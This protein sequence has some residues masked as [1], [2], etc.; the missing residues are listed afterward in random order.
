MSGQLE[1]LL[2][3]AGRAPSAH[4]T[5]PW[6]VSPSG[7]LGYALSWDAARELPVGDPTRR[8]LFLALGAFTEAFL[9]ASADLGVPLRVEWTG[10]SERGPV[11]R[12]VRAYE[13]HPT[14]FTAADLA[15]RRSARGAYEPGALPDAVF[16][17]A[18]DAFAGSA[19]L[20][21]GGTRAL[22]P[23]SEEADRWLF[24][25][26]AL[27]AELRRWLRLRPV[28]AGHPDARDGLTGPALALSRVEERA[29]RAAL[30]PAAHRVLR[31]VGL[32]RALAAALRG[33]MRYDGTVLVVTAPTV[34][35]EPKHLLEAGR[36]LLRCWLTLARHGY[37][38]H[39]LSQLIDCGRTCGELA[40][41]VG[42]VPWAVFRVGRPVREPVR[43]ARRTD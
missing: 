21:R 18:G 41:R 10:A 9:I 17:E 27:V 14:P 15:G 20:W 8:D 19:G 22:A 39:P 37:A 3:A 7:A 30:S 34:P 13:C 23:L 43:S 29:L 11:A 5:Q 24:A 38:T 2:R 33:V 16:A 6:T 28:P 35:A 4:N 12:F 26:P 32:A 31:R 25:D 40:D 42:A 1:E 36:G